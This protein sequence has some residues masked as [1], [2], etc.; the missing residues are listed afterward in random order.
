MK[1]STPVQEQ[2]TESRQAAC[3]SDWRML[4]VATSR[5][6]VLSSENQSSPHPIEKRMRCFQKENPCNAIAQSPT[7][8]RPKHSQL[9]WPRHYGAN[10]CTKLSQIFIATGDHASDQKIQKLKSL[11]DIQRSPQRYHNLVQESLPEA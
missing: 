7:A 11:S 2:S 3:E 8:L 5:R 6:S 4:R 9:T 10:N 1:G